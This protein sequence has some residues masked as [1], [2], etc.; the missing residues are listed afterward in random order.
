[1]NKDKW[2]ELTILLTGEYGLDHVREIESGNHMGITKDFFTDLQIDHPD[3]WLLDAGSGRT[4]FKDL[5]KAHYMSVDIMRG[6]D[7]HNINLKDK[8]FAIV[9]C[10][11]ILEHVLSPIVCLS[12][13]TRVLKD[14]GDLIVGLPIFPDFLVRGHNYVLP[15]G[16]WKHLFTRVGLKVVTETGIVK[17]CVCFQLQKQ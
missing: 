14:D 2:N 17:G 6:Q 7:L 10:N 11:H 12:E 9:Y 16:S 4:N 8:Q 3:K 1:M 15:V 13:L 5:I